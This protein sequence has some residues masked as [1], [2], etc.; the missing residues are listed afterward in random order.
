[1]QLLTS[2]LNNTDTSLMAGDEIHAVLINEVAIIQ[3]LTKNQHR[4]IMTITSFM[5]TS[6]QL[7]EHIQG[8]M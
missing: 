1:M 8:N 3:N 6:E 5:R 2:P 4:D 7:V